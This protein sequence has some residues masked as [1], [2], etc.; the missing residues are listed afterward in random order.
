MPSLIGILNVRDD[1]DNFFPVNCSQCFVKAYAD[2]LILYELIDYKLCLKI[3]LV[4]FTRIL[5]HF[6]LTICSFVPFFTFFFFELLKKN[7][8]YEAKLCIL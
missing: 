3:N 4:E 8:H 1:C 7:D 2:F 5:T 6:F